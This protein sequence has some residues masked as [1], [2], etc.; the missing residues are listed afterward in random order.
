MLFEDTFFFS[1][2]N[3][4][5]EL[6]SVQVTG[7]RLDIT[8]TGP[9]TPSLEL[10]D[11]SSILLTGVYTKTWGTNGHTVGVAFDAVGQLTGLNL[12]NAG[13]IGTYG[14][15]ARYLYLDAFPNL[16][17]VT[18][19]NS[20]VEK[21]TGK[22]TTVASTGSL[23]VN[24]T[25]DLSGLDAVTVS[26]MGNAVA[27]VIPP[28]P[29]RLSSYDIS[30]NRIDAF[31]LPVAY[32]L[33]ET[34][35][36]G[37]G[38]TMGQT[39]GKRINA[40]DLR[41]APN[42]K[43]LY[44]N[45]VDI[46]APQ[47][48]TSTSQFLALDCNRS[49]LSAAT[50]AGTWSQLIAVV[51]GALSLTDIRL[52]VAGLTSTELAAIVDAVWAN[53]ASRPSSGTRMLSLDTQEVASP[54]PLVQTA[55]NLYPGLVYNV[56]AVDLATRNKAAALRALGWTVGLNAP[57]F[58]LTYLTAS[59]TRLTWQSDVDVD[60][61]GVGD[62]LQL[63]QVQNQPSTSTPWLALGNYTVASGSGKVWD[64]NGGMS[65]NNGATIVHGVF[66]KV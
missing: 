22:A 38:A 52:R 28:L 30:N 50:W 36:L 44:A 20:I 8:V 13:G 49:K 6:L 7:N 43:R 24:G 40:P 39:V 55:S 32:P 45:D 17:T 26:W 61:F 4:K 47:W 2:L 15:P 14:A 60:F 18:L 42:L 29:A 27:S 3:T 21:L 37:N 12:S 35:Y 59:T 9:P 25:T 33:L 31:S 34:L 63:L 58:R 11:G 10:E 65:A 16:S 57:A 53:R 23:N 62:T 19:N 56:G 46:K 1:L 41:N 64:I 66:D 51:A 48:P 54:Y 5:V